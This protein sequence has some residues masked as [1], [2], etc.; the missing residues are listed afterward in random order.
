MPFDATG[1]QQTTAATLRA[2][3]RHIEKHGWCQGEMFSDAGASCAVGAIFSVTG[4][5]GLPLCCKALEAVSEHIGCD[6]LS[7]WNDAPGRT[8]A[9]VI[10]ALRAAADSLS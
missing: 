5:V 2:A 8:A 6:K 9:E 3:A 1:F 7:E 4:L 10:A